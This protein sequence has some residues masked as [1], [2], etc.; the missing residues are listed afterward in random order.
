MPK[1][2][3]RRGQI[4]IVAGV[5]A[6][7]AGIVLA[8]VG[9]AGFDAYRLLT[10][11]AA[12]DK[13]ALINV[14]RGANCASVSQRL[15]DAGVFAAARARWYWRAYGRL[16]GE[17]SRIK[18][19][20]YRVKPEQTPRAVLAALAAGQTARTQLTIVPG[21]R[22][23]QLLHK[24]ERDPDIKHTLADKSP[25]QVMA[26]LGHADR[27]PEGR[28][29]PDTYRFPVGTTDR[30]LL[31][32]AYQAMNEFLDDVWPKR[33]DNAVVKTRYQALILASIIEKETG[34]AAERSRIAGVF[35]R[36]MR[37]QMRLQS[38]PTVI[39]GQ[40]L[41]DQELTR[42]DLEQDT[43]FNTYARAG[44]PPTPIATPSRAAIRA[45]LH[46]AP[47]DAMYFVAKGGGRHVFSKTLAGQRAAIRKYRK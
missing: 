2:Q 10:R 29:L 19:G 14:P 25:K 13:P 28:F 37:R 38:D 31:Q 47:G 9:G 3:K 43:P 45:A 7:L 39:Y 20:H 41:F 26:A 40:K 30:A 16:S 32:R 15:S 21:R 4:W 33:A 23:Q 46:P 35:S 12:L 42:A 34:L 11:S 18:S 8:L 27:T 24:I 17:C 44:L 6:V 5:A 1:K 22:F 36:R